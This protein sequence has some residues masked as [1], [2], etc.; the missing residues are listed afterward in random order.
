VTGNNVSEAVS[1]GRESNALNILGKDNGTVVTGEIASAGAVSGNNDVV[2]Q[3]ECATR[4]GVDAHVGHESSNNEVLDILFLE[5][6]VEVGSVEAVRVGLYNDSLALDG[7]NS[8]HD[9]ANRS[10]DVE[11]RSGT[12]VVLD[13]HDGDLGSAGT[14]QIF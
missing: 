8:I 14:L 1:K 2:A 9:G 7:L 10:L 5:Q 3:V 11:G 12:S 6:L 13:M 4:G